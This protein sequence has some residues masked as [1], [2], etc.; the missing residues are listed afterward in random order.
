LE[1]A[2]EL[3]RAHDLGRA[4]AATTLSLVGGGGRGVALD[5]ADRERELLLR[6]ALEQ[7]GEDDRDLAVAVLAELALSL[8]LT[9]E[10]D[11]RIALCERALLLARESGEARLLATALW[12]RRVA[13]MG[14]AGTTER[15]ADSREASALPP[16][17]VPADLAVAVQLGLVEDLLELGDRDA[18]DAALTIAR[19][20]ATDLDHPYWSWATECW[21]TLAT[22]I[23]DD[24]D[25]AEQLAFAAL[26]H[27]P[28][29]HPEAVAALGVNLVDIRLLQGRAGEMI[30]LLADAAD[31]HPNIPCYRAV[32]ALCCAASGDLAGARE[33]FDAFAARGFDVPVDSN[34]LLTIA[35]LADVAATLGDVDAG[36]ELSARLEPYADRQVILNCYGGGG[37]W[38]GPVAYHLGRLARTAGDVE[39]ARTLLRDAT[40]RCERFRAPRY[41]AWSADQECARVTSA[42]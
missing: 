42:V 30:A 6:S 37:A 39:R 32:L 25:T 31:E 35:A 23:D 29:G 13:L 12:A 9:L 16:G 10:I 11:D 18:A 24:L 3:A 5:L 27:Q 17:E 41:A 33:A 34:W 7:L 1:A 15:L 2:L 14:P 38:W 19:R 20:L 36:A 26:S 40:E 28:D 22:I 8:V 4:V 21:N